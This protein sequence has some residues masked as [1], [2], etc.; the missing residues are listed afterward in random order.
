MNDLYTNRKCTTY[1]IGEDGTS[2]PLE[3]RNKPKPKDRHTPNR[4]S[5]RKRLTSLLLITTSTG[6]NILLDCGSKINFGEV[7]RV[8][9]SLLHHLLD[10]RFLEDGASNWRAI[11][12][13]VAAAILNVEDGFGIGGGDNGFLLSSGGAKDPVL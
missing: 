9:L 11:A 5:E 1:A 12:T 13:L 7:G 4:S 8:E 2:Q 10:V 6:I 3:E